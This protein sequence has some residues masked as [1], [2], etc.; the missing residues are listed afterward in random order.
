MGFKMNNTYISSVG[1]TPLTKLGRISALVGA[2]VFA[3]QERC[4]PS[5]SVK[6]RI[7]MAMVMDAIERGVL[8]PGN[9]LVV[10]VEPSSGNTGI[11]LAAVG[12][13]LG[14]PVLIT[15]PD[16]MTVERQA[17]IRIYGA[18]L[19]LTPGAQG[20]K[21]AIAAARERVATNPDGY[22]MPMQFEN[23][24]N[25]EIHERTTAVEIAEA[26]GHV[27]MI[28]SGVG[29]GG[30]L[31]GC[32]RFFK[33]KG[34]QMIA[35]EPMTSPVIAQTLRGEVV[36]PGPHGIQGIGAGF[37]PPIMDLRLLEAV[38]A[39]DTP[40]AVAEARDLLKKDGI[41]SGI[42]GGANIAAILE[43]YRQNKIVPGSRIVTFIPD[44]ADK[45]YS[46]ALAD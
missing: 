34:T 40:V 33:S 10:I 38:V 14:I 8:R 37:V 6:D 43:L 9:P 22:F 15:M 16:T 7:A 41:S 46:T 31:T 11:G 21:G 42:S 39:I 45:Y 18:E 29:T 35:V 19:L 12:A 28:V 23:M 24:A 44:G 1:R 2:E 25:V 36:K 26:L 17:A 30:T 32:G 27:D 13:A 3:K 4:N 20:M 5:G